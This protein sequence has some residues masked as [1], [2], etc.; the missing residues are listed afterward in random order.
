MYYI[1]K[2]PDV[3]SA[4]TNGTIATS[5]T[6]ID[7]INK[8][9]TGYTNTYTFDV[10]GY[11]YSGAVTETIPRVVGES[12]VVYYDPKAPV[13]NGASITGNKRALMIMSAVAV[14]LPIFAIINFYFSSKYKSYAAMSGLSTIIH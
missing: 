8:T 4:T 14:I 2:N 13:T 6:N 7:P 3:K 1:I 9:I 12:I 5:I 10:A 11:K